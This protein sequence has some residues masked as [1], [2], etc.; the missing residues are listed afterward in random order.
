MI[1]FL[2]FAGADGWDPQLILVMGGGVAVNLAT[3]RYMAKTWATKVPPLYTV[4]ADGNSPH[5]KTFAALIPYGPSAGPNRVIDWKLLLGSAMFGVGWGLTGICP[6]PG[7]VSFVSGGSHFGVVLPAIVVGMALYE[8][9]SAFGY[10]DEAPSSECGNNSVA[11]IA[12]RA[13]CCTRPPFI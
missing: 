4:T 8:A 1:R 7:V 11:P 9:T 13:S 2:D 10:L 3:F 6:G 12:S 5:P